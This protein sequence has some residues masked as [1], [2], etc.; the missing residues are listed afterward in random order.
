MST[1]LV[2]CLTAAFCLTAC[3]AEED[4]NGTDA[5]VDM[6]AANSN[7]AGLIQLTGG[8]LD[9]GVG[10]LIPS[11][12]Y[13]NALNNEDGKSQLFPKIVTTG[14]CALISS[15]RLGSFSGLYFA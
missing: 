13:E 3:P 9:A 4:N 12:H 8:R 1:K 7:P 10:L 5:G 6:A 2:I 11:L 15:L 14:V